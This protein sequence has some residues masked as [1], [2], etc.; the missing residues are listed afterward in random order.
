VEIN[1]ADRL[2]LLRV[3]GIGPKVAEAIL[4]ARRQGRLTDLSQ[5]H[6]VGMRDP[7][8][9]SPYILLDGRRPA[10]QLSLL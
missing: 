3:P 6:A 10:Q 2:V 1:R 9:A 8:Q 7:G 5:L 4:A